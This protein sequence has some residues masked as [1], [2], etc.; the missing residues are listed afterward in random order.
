MI[1]KLG[2]IDFIV[3]IA[4]GFLA[5]QLYRSVFPAKKVEPYEQVGWSVLYSIWIVTLIKVLDAKYFGY[6][7]HSNESGFPYARFIFATQVS[8]LAVGALLAGQHELRHQ[9]SSRF[10]EKHPRLTALRPDPRSIWARVND[11]SNT[12]WAVVFLDDNSIYRGYISEFTFDP[13]AKDQDFLLSSASRV[14]DQLRELYVVNGIGVYLN[15]RSV[16][17]IE[18]IRA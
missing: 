8:G 7:L 16:R 9:V 6:F 14:D 13:D 12:D 5:T 1:D 10:G 3:Y 2:L 4:P 17:R 15:T 11:S 18:Y